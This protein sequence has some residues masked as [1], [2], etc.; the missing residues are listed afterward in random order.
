MQKLTTSPGQPKTPDG[1][2]PLANKR[3]LPHGR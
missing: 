2:K 3:G 1:G